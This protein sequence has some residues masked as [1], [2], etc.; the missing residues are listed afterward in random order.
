MILLFAVAILVGI[1]LYLVFRRV[2]FDD[3]YVGGM[4]ATEENR[5]TGVEFYNEVKEM[6]PFKKIYAMAEKKYFDIYDIG[7]NFSLWFGNIFHRLHTGLLH[8]YA[9][10]TLIGFVILAI[11]LVSAI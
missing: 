3:E 8:T 11:I 9:I 2:R 7:T 4:I 1:I 6:S 10:W 5:V